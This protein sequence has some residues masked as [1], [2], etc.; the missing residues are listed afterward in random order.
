MSEQ[1]IP[2]VSKYLRSLKKTSLI[3]IPIP[4]TTVEDETKF[5]LENAAS[6][7]TARLSNGKELLLGIWGQR[8]RLGHSKTV[9]GGLAA[10]SFSFR[11]LD[12]TPVIQRAAALIFYHEND[13]DKFVKPFVDLLE[14]SDEVETCLVVSE[15]GKMEL[16][17]FYMCQDSGEKKKSNHNGILFQTKGDFL[18]LLSMLFY[19]LGDNI[20][21]SRLQLNTAWAAGCQ[22]FVLDETKEVKTLFDLLG[23]VADTTKYDIARRNRSNVVNYLVNPI[24]EELPEELRTLKVQRELN[25][26]MVGHRENYRLLAMCA[27]VINFSSIKELWF[28]L[29][30]IELLTIVIEDHDDDNK[31]NQ[32]SESDEADV[33]DVTV[34]DV[35]VTDVT[36]V[37]TSGSTTS[38]DIPAKRFKMHDGAPQ[39]N[40]FSSFT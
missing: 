7:C 11:E 14:E 39:T 28:D 40:T 21:F 19:T 6:Y 37:A 31:D 10:T 22:R 3:S 26:H 32:S 33:T 34:T 2:K 13:V 17:R 38:D 15:G 8:F 9:P 12:L 29:L 5:F 16:C 23:D 35:T 4:P 27:N 1:I 36:G 18:C 20:P 30:P 25:L 24:L